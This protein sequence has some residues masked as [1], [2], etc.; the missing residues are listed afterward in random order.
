M[1]SPPEWEW[2]PAAQRER[3][4]EKGEREM[5]RKRNQATYYE[6]FTIRQGIGESGDTETIVQEVQTTDSLIFGSQPIYLHKW[7]ARLAN[8]F[9]VI[10]KYK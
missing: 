4:G 8:Y 6:M 5:E 10:A 9:P 7:A 3:K 1:A 2:G